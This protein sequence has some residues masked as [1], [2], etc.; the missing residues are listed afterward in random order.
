MA[1]RRQ[2]PAALPIVGAALLM[3]AATGS[4]GQADQ[5]PPTPAAKTLTLAEAVAE[6]L[7]HA[8]A[9]A[10]AAQQELAARS[11]AT[12]ARRS[13]WGEIDA[14]ASFSRYQDDQIVRP[15]ARELLDKGFAGLPFDRDQW[16]YGVAFQVPLYLG[17]RLSATITL[18]SLQADQ[19]AALLQG[20]RWQIRFNAT[21]LYASAQTLDALTESIDANLAA[22]G[23]TR[24][25][26]ELAVRLGKR[27]ELDLLK[28]DDETAVTRARRA[29]VVADRARVQALL[30]ALLGRDPAGEL[31]LEPLQDRPWALAASRDELRALALGASP[32]QRA[33]FAARQSHQAERIARSTFLPSVA[34]R[35]IFLRNDA[36]SLPEPLDTWE[37][38]VGVSVPLFTG[39]AHIA[40]LA[41]ARHAA[42]AVESGLARAQLDQ[43]ARLV[44]ALARWDAAGASLEAARAGVA[45][46][47]EAAR[48]EQ[49]RYDTGAGAM[50][51]LLRARAREL[52]AAGAFAQARG[53]RVS[54]AARLDAVCEKE[55]LP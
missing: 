27:P 31:R 44:D 28:L 46:A 32:V 26:L 54:A 42:S 25:K 18:A 52:A 55:V 37:L 1:G 40:E 33:A 38:S 34:A 8:P 53:D 51:D 6:A 15:I 7:D 14:V 4:M 47:R 5:A 39:G 36:P 11:K 43:Q 19:A 45:S 10:A 30:L 16:H 24:R 49:I 20:S 12:A 17:G 35:G 13:R 9:L 50:D 23:E 41:S 29:N 48:I 22:L 2:V 3:V 21:S